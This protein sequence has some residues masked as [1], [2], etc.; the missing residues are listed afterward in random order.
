[1]LTI[2]LFR[3]RHSRLPGHCPEPDKERCPGLTPGRTW[4]PLFSCLLAG[5][6]LFPGSSPPQAADNVQW[7]RQPF[8]FYA[9]EIG[10]EELL[11][12]FSG[13]L[14]V[15]VN[16]S[17]RAKQQ[18]VSGKFTRLNGLEFIS[19]LSRSHNLAWFF[20]GATLFVRHVNEVVREDIA[21]DAEAF[22]DA[23]FVA[24]YKSFAIDGNFNRWDVIFDGR[25]MRLRGLPEYTGF[26]RKIINFSSGDETAMHD[27][28]GS[29]GDRTVVRML[30]VRHAY[31]EQQLVN[32]ANILAKSMGVRRIDLLAD[33]PLQDGAADQAAA[34]AAPGN[35]T[36]AGGGILGGLFGQGLSSKNVEPIEMMGAAPDA[37][38]P[39]PASAETAAGGA[40]A[41]PADNVHFVSVN[42]QMRS[43]IVRDLLSRIPRYRQ[44]LQE[45]DVPERQIEISA[46]ILDINSN[47]NSNLGINIQ[48][49]QAEGLLEYT[50]TPSVINDIGTFRAR[51]F[52]LVKDGSAR[53][54][55]EPSVLTLNNRPAQFKTDQTFYVRLTGDRAVDLIPINFGT[56]LQVTPNIVGDL[57]PVDGE[58]R[59]NAKI[60]LAIHI[61][62]GVRSA[63][64]TPID[65]IPPVNNTVIDTEALV[66]Q[67]ASLL[68]GG[69]Q[70]NNE[71]EGSAGIPVLKDIPVLGLLFSTRSKTST[72]NTRYFVITTRIVDYETPEDVQREDEKANA[73]LSS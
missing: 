11:M 31:N 9:R 12:D 72:L 26:V 69:Y 10:L 62:D 22:D 45:V 61:E 52:A 4:K 20:D 70:V 41:P 65:E 55:T 34:G 3:V 13:N 40:P 17:A 39:A 49:N 16:L 8:S 15:P 46:S 64:A 21:L 63:S 33:L 48:D 57:M 23:V 67:G 47:F 44:L 30:K 29:D 28:V 14:S 50:Y 32:L 24:T 1:M 56:L 66:E 18:R 6:L 60:H 27:S 35:E 73:S 5:L 2:D 58:P 51:L 54:V 43:I 59:Q 19:L 68:I 42:T 7:Q 38:A 71:T 36:A 53:F 37:G 25:V